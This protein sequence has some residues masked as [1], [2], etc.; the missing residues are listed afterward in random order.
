MENFLIVDIVNRINRL[1]EGQVQIGTVETL[2]STSDA[3]ASLTGT[4]P[5]QFLNLGIPRGV[6]GQPGERGP[7]GAAAPHGHTAVQV[8]AIPAGTIANI[9]AL[10]QAEYDA[11]PTKAATTLYVITAPSLADPE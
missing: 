7:S 8:G 1:S 6:E 3:T 2:S 4:F 10:T 11:L 5:L 9:V